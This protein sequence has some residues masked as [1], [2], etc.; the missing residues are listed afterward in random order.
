MLGALICVGL[1]LLSTLALYSLS[2]KQASGAW[3]GVSTAEFY[4]KQPPRHAGM[5]VTAIP[6]DC[7]RAALFLVPL[8]MEP[9]AM[10]AWPQGG[11]P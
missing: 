8:F 10:I 5:G 1:L 2:E 7:L 11:S 4:Q 9:L 3:Q 6:D